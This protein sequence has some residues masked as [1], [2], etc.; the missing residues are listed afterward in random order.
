MH[1]KLSLSLSVI[2]TL[3]LLFCQFIR[4]FISFCGHLLHF[5]GRQEIKF[6]ISQHYNGFTLKN[7]CPMGFKII[8]NLEVTAFLQKQKKHYK[9]ITTMALSTQSEVSHLTF[10]MGSLSEFW[11]WE[12]ADYFKDTEK[13]RNCLLDTRK[14]VFTT[15][16]FFLD[17]SLKDIFFEVF[18]KIK[19]QKI[20]YFIKKL[21]DILNNFLHSL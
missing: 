8:E 11:L 13:A 2:C 20:A 10:R 3:R 14:A 12:F 6:L 1:D 7:R 4:G 5:G 17:Y 21:L 9:N 19:N 15:T 16:V 18:I